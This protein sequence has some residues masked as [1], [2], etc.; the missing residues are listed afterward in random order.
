LKKYFGKFSKTPGCI[1]E[2]PLNPSLQK[3]E[4]IGIAGLIEMLCI[5]TI[6]K[7]VKKIIRLN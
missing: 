4:E 2:I 1:R 5:L 6:G 3:G 7:E